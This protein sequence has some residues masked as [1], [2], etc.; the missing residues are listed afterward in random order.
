MLQ[1]NSYIYKTTLLTTGETYVGKRNALSKEDKGYFGS[2][3]ILLNKLK[4]YGRKSFTKEVL[5]E[6]IFSKSLLD[7]LE[8]HYIRLISPN[9]SKLSLNIAV[10]GDGGG[11]PGKLN[12]TYRHDIDLN[13]E[14]I[15][16]DYKNGKTLHDLSI[17]YNCSED[18]IKSRLPRE[19]FRIKGVS[20]YMLHDI[21]GIINL[22]FK[23]GYSYKEMM[24]TFGINHDEW[25]RFLSYCKPTLR[26]MDM[27][28][29]T[30]PKGFKI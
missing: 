28:D 25:I 26:T 10:G 5:I 3:N 21:K 23:G 24:V 8:R 20:W 15:I 16:N 2:G 17:E 18:T 30:F 4:K 12:S 11:R 1:T 14:T 6:G 22:V 13:L 7:S 19:I 9:E 27:K 29:M